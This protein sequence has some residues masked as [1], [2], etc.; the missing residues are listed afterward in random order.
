[1]C[2]NYRD[3]RHPCGKG[4]RFGKKRTE[5]SDYQFSPSKGFILPFHK[6]TEPIT[7][8]TSINI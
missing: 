1:M 7:T 5:F 4:D 2:V 8:T 6:S 3:S